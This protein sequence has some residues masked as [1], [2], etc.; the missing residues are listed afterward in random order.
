M[1]KGSKRRKAQIDDK[2]FQSN[3]DRIFNSQPDKGAKDNGS[4]RKKQ[5]ERE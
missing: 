1:G 3:W 2:Q 4:K 5:S